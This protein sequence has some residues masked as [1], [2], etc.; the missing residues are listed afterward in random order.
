MV[1]FQY[2]SRAWP[3]WFTAI[4]V[5]AA[6]NSQQIWPR[7]S[8]RPRSSLLLWE[9]RRVNKGGADLSG[10]WEVGRQIAANLRSP[11]IIVIKSTVP[12]GTNAELAR[13]MA[14]TTLDSL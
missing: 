5:M 8:P 10:V 13:R 12:V 4:S 2:M 7:E 14:E 6:W 9:R 3:N 11:K 1:R